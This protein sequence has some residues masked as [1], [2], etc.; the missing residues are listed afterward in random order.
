MGESKPA[1][2]AHLVWDGIVCVVSVFGSATG[3]GSLAELLIGV[4]G[5]LPTA[6]LG[7]SA[8]VQRMEARDARRI[9]IE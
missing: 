4:V 9:I 2:L 3:E 5:L 6:L 8:I 1:L 7:T